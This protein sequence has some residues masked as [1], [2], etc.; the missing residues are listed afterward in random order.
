MDALIVVIAVVR[1]KPLQHGK[2]SLWLLDL[3]WGIRLRLGRGILV[4]LHAPAL[5]SA[6]ITGQRED[7]RMA[8]GHDLE[9][10]GVGVIQ[11]RVDAL[12]DDVAVDQVI[13]HEDGAVGARL[14][15][16]LVHLCLELEAQLGGEVELVK[17]CV[18]RRKLPVGLE[19]GGRVLTWGAESDAR[20]GRTVTP[21]ERSV[22][23]H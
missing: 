22:T 17:G 18:L 10:V 3:D 8:L 23:H 19:A 20:G 7:F 12:V 6:G 16:P 4:D 11:G 9:H 14:L 15:V 21:M 1:I 13:E 2:R 5:G